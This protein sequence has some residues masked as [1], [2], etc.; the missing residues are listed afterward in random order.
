[1]FESRHFKNQNLARK[2]EL[3]RTTFL[4]LVP[5]RSPQLCHKVHLCGSCMLEKT[6]SQSL[7]RE[8]CKQ[9]HHRQWRYISTDEAVLDETNGKTN[10]FWT[11]KDQLSGLEIW[12]LWIRHN[13]ES[14]CIEGRA[15]SIWSSLRSWLMNCCCD[16]IPQ[17]FDIWELAE[18]NVSKR[19]RKGRFS[20]SARWEL[21]CVLS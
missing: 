20:D 8:P 15:W 17:M 7:E 2:L 10:S 18:E 16:A 9:L 19:L 1:M 11:R 12:L 13:A 3:M 14:T 6:R 4:I 5:R 21:V